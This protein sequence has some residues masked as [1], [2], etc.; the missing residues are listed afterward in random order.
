MNNSIFSSTDARTFTILKKIVNGEILLPEEQAYLNEWQQSSPERELLINEL[1]DTDHIISALSQLH[2]FGENAEGRY[3]QFLSEIKPAI[4]VRRVHFL[5]A[6]W[7]RWA[8]VLLISFGAATYI[9]FNTSGYKKSE[10]ASGQSSP[11]FEDEFPGA[12]RAILTLSDGRK[13]NLDS[14]TGNTIAEGE[15]SIGHNNGELEYAA[16]EKMVFNTVT[17]PK[18]GQYKLSLADGTKVWLNA[19]SSI[20]FPTSFNTSSRQIELSGEAYLEIAKDKAKPFIIRSGN[21]QVEVLGTS[22]NINNY[23]DEPAFKTTLIEGAIKVNNVIIKPGEAF[24]NGRTVKADIAKDIAWKNGFF[25]FDNTSLAGMLR[26]LSRWYDIEIVYEGKIPD[27][28][29]EGRVPRDLKLS[30]VL[31]LL[32]N[33]EVKY[34]KK[35]KILFIK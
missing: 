12:D 8:A 5:Q 11:V 7:I 23:K 14:S 28:T 17:T 2:E 22:L 16:S 4:P 24:E 10:L 31:L 21:N 26:Q 33:L 3:D 19:A 35:G 18:G 32:N 34:E 30:E 13:V 1:G 15:L 9:Y 29:L 25:N 20:T 6:A 27:L